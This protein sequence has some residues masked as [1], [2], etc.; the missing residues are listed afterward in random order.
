MI[1]R[2]MAGQISDKQLMDLLMEDIYGS[3]RRGYLLDDDEV[4]ALSEPPSSSEYDYDALAQ[5]LQ[6]GQGS[7]TAS[8]PG[9]GFAALLELMFN[10]VLAQ[11]VSQALESNPPQSTKSQMMP[12]KNQMELLDNG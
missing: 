7:L 6:D 9:G 2:R 11:R 8:Q 10:P 5:V 4:K 12:I 1:K 3:V